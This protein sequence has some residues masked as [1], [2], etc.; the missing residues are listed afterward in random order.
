MHGEHAPFRFRGLGPGPCRFALQSPQGR[1]YHLEADLVMPIPGFVKRRAESR[2]I[3]TALE[4]LRRRAES[5][6]AS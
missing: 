1:R 4:D 2:I 6:V 5:S 3:R